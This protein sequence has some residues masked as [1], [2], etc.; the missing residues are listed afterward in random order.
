MLYVSPKQQRMLKL[1]KDYVAEHSYSPS[2]RELCALA[3]LKSSSTAHGYME[4]LK[5]KGLISW[6]PTHPRTI[7]VNS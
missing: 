2:V 1:I 7:K 4:R 3:G 5:S 6:E